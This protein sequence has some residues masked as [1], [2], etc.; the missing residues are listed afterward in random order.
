MA[1]AL[2]L[3]RGSSYTFPVLSID[4]RNIGDST[5][6]ISELERRVPEPALYPEDPDDRRRAL[7]IE[8]F[9]DE[10]LG[11]HSRLLAWHELGKDRDRFREVV[12]GSLPA[13]LRQVGGAATSYAGIFT[14]LR[15]G[16]GDDEAA[17]LARRKI[18]AAFDRL[19]TELDLSGGEYLAGD[20][21]SVADLTAAALLY[22]VVL[23]PEAPIVD[24]DSGVPA[25]INEFRKPLRERP[26]YL[27]VEE[28]Y[29]RHRLPAPAAVATG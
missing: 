11:P 23:P 5:T 12:E 21:F 24:G 1:V 3:T 28:M 16:V 19:E 25:G 2:W 15:F 4:G 17:E 29:R 26:G 22:P 27:W 8:D 6:I 14:R 20:G 7:E 9:F 18:L 10:E 13:P